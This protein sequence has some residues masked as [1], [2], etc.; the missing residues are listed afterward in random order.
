MKKLSGLVDRN[1]IAPIT[2]G[3]NYQ[4]RYKVLAE[5]RKALEEGNRQKAK[6]LAERNLVGP[7][8]AQYGRYLSLVISL[9]SLTTKRKAW[10]VL[11]TIIVA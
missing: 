6:Q 11:P 2:M 7:N 4:D 8:N 1:R 3:G 5:I 9:W 10:R